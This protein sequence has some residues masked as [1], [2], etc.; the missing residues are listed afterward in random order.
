MKLQEIASQKE[1]TQKLNADKKNYLLLYKKGSESSECALGHIRDITEEFE[2]LNVF[3][4]DVSQVR[5]IHPNYGIDT[6]PSLLIFEGKEFKK[7]VKGCSTKEYYKSLFESRVFSA[8]SAE[9]E[10]QKSVTVYSTPT[11]SWCNTLK[12]HLRKNG[13][14]FTDVD[15]STDQEMAQDLVRKSGQQGV[16]QTEIDGEIIVGFDKSRINKLLGIN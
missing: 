5:D 16:P 8:S 2:N 13:V 10:P 12:S 1:L 9:S 6:A 3:T 14:Y 15:V 11:C 7:T 4:A